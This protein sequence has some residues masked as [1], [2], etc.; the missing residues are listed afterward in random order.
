MIE[1]GFDDP[2]G[3]VDPDLGQPMCLCC[4]EKPAICHDTDLGPV[5]GDCSHYLGTAIAWLVNTPGIA[6]HASTETN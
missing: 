1:S 3:E 4:E 6:V 5:C 2:W